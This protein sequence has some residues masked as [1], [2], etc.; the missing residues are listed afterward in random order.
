VVSDG[1]PARGEDVVSEEEGDY[2]GI[3]VTE[4]FTHTSPFAT[5]DGKD[6]YLSSVAANED[7]FLGYRFDIRDELYGAD[8]ARVRFTA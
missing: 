8:S 6:R 5:I 3:P 2:R 4:G 1:A 7:R